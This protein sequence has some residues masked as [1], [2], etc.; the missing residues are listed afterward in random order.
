MLWDILPPLAARL[1]VAVFRPLSSRLL[2]VGVQTVG[3]AEELVLRQFV[4]SAGFPHDLLGL[5]NVA[6]Q[7][8]LG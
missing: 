7:E 1:A 3:N 6:S 2:A 5:L 8:V 4:L